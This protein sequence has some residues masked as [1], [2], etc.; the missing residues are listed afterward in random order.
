M[1]TTK[2]HDSFV[3]GPMRLKGINQVPGIG[4]VLAS[5]F[6]EDN[7]NQVSGDVVGKRCNLPSC[8]VFVCIARFKLR[9]D[10]GI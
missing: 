6:V 8:M 9:R 4:R 10:V 7:I 5:R 1:T 2:K 3:S